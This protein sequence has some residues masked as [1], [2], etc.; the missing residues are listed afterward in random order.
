MLRSEDK[1][2]LRQKLEVLGEKE[3][4]LTLHEGRYHQARRMFAAA[5]N[6][7]ISLKRLSIGG[8]K[9]PED[10]PEGGW[11]RLDDGGL[12]TLFGKA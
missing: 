4:L 6:H 1:P 10:L 3:A 12:R 8:L 2:L 9:L 11:V 5:G 7:V